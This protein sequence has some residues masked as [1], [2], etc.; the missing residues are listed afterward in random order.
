MYVLRNSKS[1]QERL[2]VLFLVLLTALVFTGCGGSIE[3]IEKKNIPTDLKPSSPQNQSPKGRKSPE[4]SNEKPKNKPTEPKDI[5]TDSKKKPSEPSTQ[6]SQ[7]KVPNKT[8]EKERCNGLDDDKDGKVD[9]AV[10]LQGCKF[11]MVLR[12]KHTRTHEPKDIGIN[13]ATGTCDPGSKTRLSFITG[14]GA[15]VPIL[16]AG[17]KNNGKMSFSNGERTILTL[18]IPN[19]GLLKVDLLW[20]HTDL[21]NQIVNTITLYSLKKIENRAKRAEICNGIDDDKDGPIDEGGVCTRG[22]HFP[23]R[24]HPHQLKLY[25]NI[26]KGTCD[27]KGEQ[28]RFSVGHGT[29]LI[30]LPRGWSA[31]WKMTGRTYNKQTNVQI[32]WSFFDTI[33]FHTPKGQFRLLLQ[34]QNGGLVIHSIDKT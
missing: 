3:I 33:T 12:T 4:V 28:I 11:P 14:H 24:G 29:L 1:S 31:S 7:P 18:E 25:V 2:S 13:V 27:P 20:R 19:R 22:C 23:M 26:A 16:P 8:G 6:P 5:P 10:C 9:E 21:R 17:W 34:W 32:P 15:L 30:Y